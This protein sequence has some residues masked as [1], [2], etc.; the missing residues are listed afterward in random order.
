M[1]ASKD[2]F[3]LGPIKDVVEYRSSAIP[4]EHLFFRATRKSM[5]GLEERIVEFEMNQ[6]NRYQIDHDYTKKY[7]YGIET[8]GG[9]KLFIVFDED[10]V[11]IGSVKF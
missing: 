5:R 3:Q 4:L 9:N 11:E 8:I 10:W 2:K 1:A 7:V 6:R